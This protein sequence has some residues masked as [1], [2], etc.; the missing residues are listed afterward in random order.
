MDPSDP[1]P[2]A[3]DRGTD[4]VD[5]SD[6]AR[7]ENPVRDQP[8]ASGGPVPSDEDQDGWVPA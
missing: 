2:A 4:P 3:S 1:V 5:E 7:S 8:P 6:A